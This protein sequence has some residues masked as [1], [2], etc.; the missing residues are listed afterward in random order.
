MNKR[1]SFLWLQAV[2]RF[3]TAVCN[4]AQTPDEIMPSLNYV[5]LICDFNAYMGNDRVI[6]K[7]DL[8]NLRNN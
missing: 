2:G 4:F 3:L 8:G 6:W 1:V 5:F 7:G